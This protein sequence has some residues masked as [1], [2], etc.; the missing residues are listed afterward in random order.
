MCV[1]AMFLWIHFIFCSDEHA[2]C[3]G[4][5]KRLATWLTSPWSFPLLDLAIAVMASETTATDMAEEQAESS[6][7]ATVASPKRIGRP[8]TGS[9]P[10]IDIDDEIQEANRLAEVTKRMMQAAKA[11][12]RNSRR[13]KQRLVRKAGK[14]SAADLER[15]ATLKR[16]G[17]F[18]AEPSE[19]SSSSSSAA[20]SS[21][22]GSATSGSEPVRRVNSK[23]FSAVGQV[24][25][26][27]DLLACMQQ[28]GA[29]SSSSDAVTSAATSSGAGSRTTERPVPRGTRLSPPG[30]STANASALSVSNL[31]GS[32]PATPPVEEGD[33]S[34]E[35]DGDVAM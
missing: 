26:A 18:V 14:L 24:Q 25:G 3:C 6:V 22:S 7:V 30:A 8:K 13:T 27:A 33:V 16:C 31:A 21:S 12:Q 10:K 11:A 9:R 2:A 5:K 34:E 15:I 23:L 29:G 19:G 1:F 20:M 28:H 4:H 32:V 35:Q 17:L